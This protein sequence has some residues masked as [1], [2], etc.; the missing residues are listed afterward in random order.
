MAGD[1]ADKEM[2][3]EGTYRTLP[4]PTAIYPRDERMSERI[5]P[6]DERMSEES[7]PR[8]NNVTE[9]LR[10]AGSITRHDE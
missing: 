8:V 2:M 10:V 9:K 1:L 4:M 6:R 5:Y 3:R 7:V